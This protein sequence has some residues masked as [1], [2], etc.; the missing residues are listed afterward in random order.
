MS[1]L[2]TK[3]EHVHRLVERDVELAG[4][5]GL[6]RQATGGG[7]GVLLVEGGAGVGKTCLLQD[8]VDLARD[9]PVEL[10]QAR[11]G[12]LERTFPFGI[13]GQLLGAAVAS[14]NADEQ[15]TVRGD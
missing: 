7:S 3:A 14:L 1:R 2:P 10:L 12:E 11:G 6:L 15:A 4:I 8:L 9:E 5:A 13:A